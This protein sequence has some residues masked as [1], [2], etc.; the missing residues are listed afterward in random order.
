MRCVGNQVFIKLHT[1][2]GKIY[3]N[4]IMFVV[5]FA[6]YPRLGLHKFLN[7]I[8]LRVVHMAAC[9]EAGT[10]LMK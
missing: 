1:V 4:F 7:N 10:I 3:L 2:P 8:K 6:F 9:F 5:L